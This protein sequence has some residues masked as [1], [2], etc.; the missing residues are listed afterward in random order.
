MI[1]LPSIFKP[2]YEYDIIRLGINYDGGYLVSRAS[3]LNSDYLYSFGISTNWDFEKDFINLNNVKLFAYDGSISPESWNELI[4]KKLKKGSFSKALKLIYKKNRF[5]NFFN[6]NNF[7]SKN[8]GNINPNS[9]SLRQILSNRGKNKIFFKIDIEGSE[10]EILEEIM[11]FQ[12]QIS[13]LCIEF[14]SCNKNLH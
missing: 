12:N 11:H 5:Y 6:Q 14:H 2:K 9:I 8:I 13:G 10:Y 7:I 3:V 4:I 1:L